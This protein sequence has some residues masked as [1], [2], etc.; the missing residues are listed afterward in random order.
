MTEEGK[1]RN[2]E[3]KIDNTYVHSLQKHLHVFCAEGKQPRWERDHSRIQIVS[4]R[5]A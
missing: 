4:I 1:E 3:V 2:I 5:D